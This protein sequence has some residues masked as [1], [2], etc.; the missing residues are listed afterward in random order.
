M[1]PGKEPVRGQRA[2]AETARQGVA[3]VPAAVRR[4]VGRGPPGT[5]GHGRQVDQRH[6][7]ARE[8]VGS[9]GAHASAAHP[10]RRQATALLRDLWRHRRL[11][12]ENDGTEKRPVARRGAAAAGRH[13]PPPRRPRPDR[14]RDS[15]DRRNA[16]P[17]PLAARYVRSLP[18]ARA[19]DT[20]M[21]R[22]TGH[23]S[24]TRPRLA[25]RA[26]WG[27]VSRFA[28]RGEPRM[29]LAELLVPEFDEEMTATRRVLERVPDGKASWKPHPKS[30]TLGR[31][32]T[33]V[34]ELPGWVVNTITRDELDIMPPG[35]PPPKVEALDS[36]ARILELFDR[37]AKAARAAL[38]KTSDPE[39]KKPWAF[40]VSGRT[41]DTSPKYTVYRRT[42]LNHLAHHRGQLTVYLRLNGAPV[43]AVYGPTADEPS[44]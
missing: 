12:R 30:M 44:F 9:G 41:V 17:P 42:V 33:L 34:A 38:A 29:A 25:G 31:L 7:R 1:L 6:H 18:E 40:K 28:L 16:L 11:Q 2:A 32:A 13:P 15:G 39:F 14:A 36:T 26:V 21:A 20:R 24:P 35:G 4:P 10:R 22:T 5:W 37:N 43:P 23:P 3:V 8:L 19:G 27:V